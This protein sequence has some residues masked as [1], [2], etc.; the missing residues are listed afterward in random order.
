[1][2]HLPLLETWYRRVWQ[3]ADLSAIDEMFAPDMVEHG[4]VP[5]L[6]VNP[7]EFRAIVP[8]LLDLVDEP[9]FTI[10]RSVEC[11]DWLTAVVQLDAV[12]SEHGRPVAA[13]GQ[14]LMRVAA[15]RIVEVYNH[16]D[17]LS[18]FEQLGLLPDNTMLLCLSG[19]RV[20]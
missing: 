19:D 5:G 17:F 4:L 20:G 7:E 16:F 8:A 14:V 6:S 18:L 13:S 12:A 15:G 11:D 10:S 1:M 2:S 3:E 9:R